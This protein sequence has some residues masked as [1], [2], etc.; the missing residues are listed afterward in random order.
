MGGWTIDYSQWP[1]VAV[2]S[3]K[4]AY[5]WWH[6]AGLALVSKLCT[7]AYQRQHPGAMGHVVGYNHNF[8]LGG[9]TPPPIVL[10]LIN[11]IGREDTDFVRKELTHFKVVEP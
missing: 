1:A 4:G 6:A 5:E 9:Y 2:Q 7:E 8:Y 11:A 10:T 3:P